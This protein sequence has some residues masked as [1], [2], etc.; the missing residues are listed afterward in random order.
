[1]RS[2]WGQSL[3]FAEEEFVPQSGAQTTES[4]GHGRLRKT[5]AF[6]S[7]HRRMLV[8]ERIENAQKIEIEG[9]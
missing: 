7:A 4:C 6:A 5:D 8:Q 9:M 2:P 3:H 1:M